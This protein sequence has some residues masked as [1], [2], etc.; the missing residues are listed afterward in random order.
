MKKIYSQSEAMAIED[1]CEELYS[2]G[3]QSVID[4]CDSLGLDYGYCTQCENS[5]PFVST[6]KWLACCVCGHSTNL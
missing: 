4:Y 1:K 6:H 3:I 2:N 5:Y